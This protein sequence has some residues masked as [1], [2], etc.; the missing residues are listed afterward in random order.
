MSNLPEFK[1]VLR[2]DLKQNLEFLPTQA[3]NT[4][5]GW[6]VRCAVPEGVDIYPFE[7]KLIDT[8]LR[9]FCP[10][11]WYLELRPRSSTH[12]KKNLNCL[13]GIIDNGYENT[14]YVSA[15][16]LPDVSTAQIYHGTSFRNWATESNKVLHIP[17]GERIAQLI[18]K[19]VEEVSMT[20]VSL[21]DFNK[22][23]EERGASRALG[24]FGSSGSK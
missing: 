16:W 5:T 9:V 20:S 12:A 23:C 1:F 14:I 11:G 17:F 19:R 22:L 2:D 18:P 10:E 15:Q 6:D 24:G 21:D 3:N 7:Y 8:G 13:Y 4:D